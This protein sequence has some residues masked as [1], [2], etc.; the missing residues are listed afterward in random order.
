MVTTYT[1]SV[2]S[3]E[4]KQWQSE[5]NT[6]KVTV[7]PPKEFGGEANT[8]SPEHLYALSLLNCYIATVKVIARKSNYD[9]GELSAT[10]HVDLDTSKETPL[11]NAHIILKPEKNTK[12][13]KH[14]M[15]KAK[16]HCYVHQSV[17]T[18]ITITCE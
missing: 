12:K 4:G 6:Q 10:I 14:V 18:D 1:A 7:S 9:L 17:H 3:V 2:K 15:R 5:A 11:S 8:A 13:F 16:E